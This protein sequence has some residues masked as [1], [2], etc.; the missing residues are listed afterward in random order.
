MSGA[1]LYINGLSFGLYLMQEPWDSE[2]VRSRLGEDALDQGVI[3]TKCAGDIVC[4][5][6]SSVISSLISVIKSSDDGQFAKL[7]PQLADIVSFLNVSAFD[8]LTNQVDGPM[9]NSKNLVMISTQP[10]RFA[11]NDLDLSA[12]VFPWIGVLPAIPGGG[13]W[14]QNTLKRLMRLFPALQSSYLNI[15]HQIK[16]FSNE[17][18]SPFYSRLLAHHNLMTMTVNLF[19]RTHSLDYGYSPA[20][21]KSALT[22]PFN[23]TSL[24]Y[25]SLNA[26]LT[27]RMASLQN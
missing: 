13:N 15:F 5:D 12:G 14:W 8:V 3:A 27:L 6:N 7:F 18:V 16:F 17:T 20:V 22:D 26:F 23:M 1:V 10:V 9:F 4:K 11:R 24:P 21:V 25:G 19:D 2:M